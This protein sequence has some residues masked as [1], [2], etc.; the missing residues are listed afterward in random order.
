MVPSKGV[1]WHSIEL[2][3]DLKET[4]QTPAFMPCSNLIISTTYYVQVGYYFPRMAV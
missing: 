1:N 3:E 4:Y 2:T